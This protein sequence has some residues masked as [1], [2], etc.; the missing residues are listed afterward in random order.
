MMFETDS[1]QELFARI[2]AVRTHRNEFLAEIE[3]APLA[4]ADIFERA[5]V[6]PIISTMK[7]LGAIEALPDV[8]KVQTRRA[9]EQIGVTEDS[10]IGDVP[11]SA[12]ELLPS[13]LA[14]HAR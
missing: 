9:L 14:R 10:L 13:A 5:S 12:A 6:D 8:G 7:V 2:D 11:P 3:A 1:Y 4:C